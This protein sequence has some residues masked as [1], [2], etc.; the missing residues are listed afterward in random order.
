MGKNVEIMATCLDE[1]MKIARRKNPNFVAV[2]GHEIRMV[3]KKYRVR[4]RL[5]KR[6]GK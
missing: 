1:A 4:M 6:G 2:S 5:R 3:T